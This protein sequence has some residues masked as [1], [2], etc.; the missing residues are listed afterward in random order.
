M[1]AVPE[2]N[3]VVINYAERREKVV[4]VELKFR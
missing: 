2:G 1:G 3:A 4:K